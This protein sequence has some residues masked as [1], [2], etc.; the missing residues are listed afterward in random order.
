MPGGLTMKCLHQ[1]RLVGPLFALLLVAGCTSMFRGDVVT[2]H[3]GPLPAGETIRVVASDPAKQASL[4]FRNYA[5]LINEQ[6]RRIGYEPTTSNDAELIAE[7]DYRVEAESQS[8]TVDRSRPYVRYHFGY[9]RYYDPFYYGFYNDWGPD[10]YTTRPSY[11][12]TLE[13][14]I[15]HNDEERERIFEG[16]VQST[17]LQNLLPEVMPYLVTAM[18]ENYPGE[19][20]VTK[21]VTIERDE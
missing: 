6:L 3:E 5:N 12:R 4:E 2:F 11:L 20:G 18:F 17:G 16:R 8:V 9:G 21:V 10:V 1:L 7:V 14:N 15:A 13:L 19:N